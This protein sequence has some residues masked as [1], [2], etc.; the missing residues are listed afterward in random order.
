MHNGGFQKSGVQNSGMQNA[1]CND[2]GFYAVFFYSFSVFLIAT[3]SIVSDE[4]E[5][6]RFSQYV[7]QRVHT[8]VLKTAIM[9]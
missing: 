5:A 6:S 4:R 2:F 1:K 8:A 7:R 3:G 9:H